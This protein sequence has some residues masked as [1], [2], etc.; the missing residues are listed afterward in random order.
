MDESLV[1][2]CSMPAQTVATITYSFKAGR[3]K[4]NVDSWQSLNPS[5][6]LCLFS[7]FP[8][9]LDC[10]AHFAGILSSGD[11][12]GECLESAFEINSVSN[13]KEK[14]ALKFFGETGPDKDVSFL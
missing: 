7:L 14:K 10:L 8:C 6:S 5:G 4:G 9:R 3:G 2:H 1:S 13:A 12:I 11:L